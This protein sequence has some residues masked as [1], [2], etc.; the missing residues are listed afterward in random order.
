[1]KSITVFV[2]LFVFLC[3]SGIATADNDKDEY[4][5]TTDSVLIVRNILR[6]YHVFIRQ[7]SDATG[8][9]AEI[10]IALIASESEGIITSLSKKKAKGLMQ[11]RAIADKETGIVCRDKTAACQIKK[12]AHYLKYLV[13]EKKIPKWSRVFLAY[14]EGVMGSKKFS[15]H[16]TLRHAHVIKCNYYLSVVQK[17]FQETVK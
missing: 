11:T 2:L 15:S 10:I 7:E 9:P 3:S 6:N 4:K 5:K 8:I 17:V 13:D 16:Q 1:M 14:N 12:G